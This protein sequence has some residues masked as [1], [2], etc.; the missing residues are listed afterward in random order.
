MT[1]GEKE[2]E[3]L[4]RISQVAM[5]RPHTVS[6]LM[7]EVL[8]IMETELGVSR[9]TLTLRKPDTDIFII[10]ASRGLTPTEEQRGQYKVGEGVTG[11]VAQT[12]ESAL[13]PDINT[14]PRFLNR[15]LSRTDKKTAFIC[16]PIVHQKLVI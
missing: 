13:I 11:H 8:D 12:G 16:V 3:I 15:T 5:T 2:M 6:E 14:D 4:Y 9:G 10:E 7:V 1:Q